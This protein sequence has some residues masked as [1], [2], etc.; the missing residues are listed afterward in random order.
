MGKCLNE[1]THL[2]ILMSPHLVGANL[3]CTLALSLDS[4]RCIKWLYIFLRP[5]LSY[6]IN[7]DG[8]HFCN[9]SAYGFELY[10]TVAMISSWILSCNR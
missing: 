1:Q 2:V 3:F 7:T 4:A 9:G 10:A 5:Q 6:E 8:L